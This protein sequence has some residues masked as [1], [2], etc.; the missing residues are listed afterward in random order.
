MLID[1]LAMGCFIICLA[2]A[3]LYNALAP[4]YRSRVGWYIMPLLL[5][6][7]AMM[8]VTSARRFFGDDYPGREVLIGG[9]YAFVA[10][11]VASIGVGIVRAQFAGRERYRRA[12]S[13]ANHPSNQ[14]NGKLHE[15]Q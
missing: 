9:T 4:W 15:T 1:L 3:C 11:C 8:A 13:L 12:H 7:T 14:E 2:V 5:S 6:L 10:A